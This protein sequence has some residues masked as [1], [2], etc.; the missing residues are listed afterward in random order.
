MA[1]GPAALAA[2]A[3]FAGAAFYLSFAEHPARLGLDDRAALAEWKP[4]YRR[5][6]IMQASLAVAGFLFGVGAWMQDGNVGW[7]VGAVVL[8]ANWPFTLLA[9][10]PTNN[11][12]MNMPLDQA[13]PQSRALLE[14][15]GKLH[16]VRTAL[17]VVSAGIFLWLLS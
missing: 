7:L 3:V 1:F 9:I 14:R 4:S 11:L 12:L 5:G 2:A 8:L 13:G 17:G 15:W 16:A 6:F 10:M